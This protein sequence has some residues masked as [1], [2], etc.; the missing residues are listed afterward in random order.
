MKDSL[1]QHNIVPNQDEFIKPTSEELDAVYEQLDQLSEVASMTDQ[2]RLA[3]DYVRHE[4]VTGD[5]SPRKY[6]DVTGLIAQLNNMLAKLPRSIG[7]F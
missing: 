1:E 2:V 6:Q 3:L 5:D 4:A 7:S